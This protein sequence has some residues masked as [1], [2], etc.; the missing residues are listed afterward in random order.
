MSDADGNPYTTGPTP[1]N[2]ATL[3]RLYE[4]KGM[5]IAEIADELGY[6]DSTV[7]EWFDEFDIEL[8]SSGKRSREVYE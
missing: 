6:N 2:E 1:R 3:R 8:R 7:R 4:D 5:T